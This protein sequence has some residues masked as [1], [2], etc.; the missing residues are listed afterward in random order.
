MGVAMTARPVLA[1]LAL[2]LASAAHADSLRGGGFSFPDALPELGRSLEVVGQ[3]DLGAGDPPFEPVTGEY[4]WT[5]YGSSVHEVEEPSPGIRY[6]H[7]TFGILEIRADPAFNSAYAPLPPNSVVPR[8]FHDGEIV[9]LGSVTDLTIREIFGIATA[10]GDVRFVAGS[11]LPLS[12]PDWTLDAAVSAEGG[13]D[14]PEGYGARWNLELA[15]AKPVH[16]NPVT[17]TAIKALYR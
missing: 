11:A 15:P 5:L 10:A 14:I 9:L 17:W 12:S 8:T 6:L 1:A 13:G 2:A 7:L 3:L 16:V 4:T